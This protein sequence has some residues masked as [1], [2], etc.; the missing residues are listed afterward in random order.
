M[1][2]ELQRETGCEGVGDLDV[3]PGK[4][5]LERTGAGTFLRISL[6]LSGRLTFVARTAVQVKL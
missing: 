5:L 3:E 4:E 2:E 1:E 6:G